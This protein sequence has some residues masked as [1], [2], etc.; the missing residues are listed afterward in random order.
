M[1]LK[2]TLSAPSVAASGFAPAELAR[3]L[4]VRTTTA[5]SGDQTWT[6]RRWI[7]NGDGSL[8]LD[9]PP[10]D[11]PVQ[12]VG[13]IPVSGLA[14]D[15][16]MSAAS[17]KRTFAL[18]GKVEL[19]DASRGAATEAN[20]GINVVGN[21]G[22]V[23]LGTPSTF[24]P[25]APVRLLDTRSGTGAPKGPVG[26]GGTVNLK[27]AG[28]G[29]VPESGVTAVVLNVTATN[30]T[31]AGF[32]TAHPHG[33]ARPT[34]SNLNFTPGQTVP[35]QVTVPVG[36]DGT[37]DLYNHAGTVDVLADISGW[38]SDEGSVFVP[39]GPTRILD[40]RSGIGHSGKVG[41]GYNYVCVR[42][43]SWRN[44]VPPFGVT[45]V[46]LNVTATNPSQASF[47]SVWGTDVV[48]KNPA[49]R[50]PTVSHLN[51]TA[52]RTV[53]NAVTTVAPECVHFDN[54]AGTVDM[55]ADMAGWFSS[56]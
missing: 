30:P 51:Y 19:V 37:V 31:A 53:A 20:V 46:A 39:T 5:H 56:L 43:N 52:G 55:I 33:T 12:E 36:P 14:L 44:G 25:T 50:A 6:A 49:R 41:P 8:T 35:N 3:L 38:Y 54:Y 1:K 27:V 48:D 34:A 47:A 10:F 9:I 32:L 15:I 45:D 7:V 28:R 18:A 42:A 13:G 23:R 4:A 26:P 40:T 24:V 2:L 17:M 11:L 22:T 29:G 16:E 21:G